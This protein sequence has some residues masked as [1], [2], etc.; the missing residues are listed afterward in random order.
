MSGLLDT[1]GVRTEAMR[2]GPYKALPSPL[3]PMTEPTRT[4]VQGPVDDMQD[5]FVAKVAARR[6]FDMV[7]ARS[8]A[9]GGVFSGQQ[10]LA[11]GLIDAIGGETEALAWLA[12]AHGIDP[13]L[14]LVDATWGDEPIGVLDGVLGWSG[15]TSL[16][17][18]LILDGLVS[19]W[20]P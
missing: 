1:L 3:K 8:L 7:R 11:V 12:E 10:A 20:H 13:D 19:V 6:G 17:E 2:S 5:L 16:P 15:K 14:P 18:P 4:E 9:D